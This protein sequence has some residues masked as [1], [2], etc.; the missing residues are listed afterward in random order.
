MGSYL[1][2]LFVVRGLNTYDMHHDMHPKATLNQD[3]VL[4]VPLSIYRCIVYHGPINCT[5][6]SLLLL[7]YCGLYFK[8]FRNDYIFSN[9]KHGNINDML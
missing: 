5:A 3:S 6:K 7:A 9:H 4:F 8:W 2:T 1:C